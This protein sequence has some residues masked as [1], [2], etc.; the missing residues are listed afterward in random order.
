MI[1]TNKKIPNGEIM[2]KIFLI[3]HGANV[4]QNWEDDV[5]TRFMEGDLIIRDNRSNTP[6]TLA[7]YYMDREGNLTILFSYH[8]KMKQIVKILVDHG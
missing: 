8:I 7:C 6:L 4:N 5:L 3:K 1:N 2:I